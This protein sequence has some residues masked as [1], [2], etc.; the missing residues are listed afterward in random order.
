MVVDLEA[1]TTYRCRCWPEH[2]SRRRARRLSREVP[3]RFETIERLPLG[4]AASWVGE[5][6][7]RTRGEFVLVL[8]GRAPAASGGGTA[9]LEVLE[10]LLS[11]LP[12]K[13][14]VAVAA[15]ITGA[16]RNDLYRA[17]L[18]MKNGARHK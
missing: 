3:K 12:V 2:V 14:A 18:E 15:R 10:M 16:R 7:D 5:D 8:E 1:N 9:P 17:A 13:T 4:K 11:E 6:P